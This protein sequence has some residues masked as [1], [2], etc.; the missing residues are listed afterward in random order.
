MALDLICYCTRP[1][2]EAE[3]LRSQV[4][5]KLGLRYGTGLV[6]YKV[7]DADEIDREIAGEFGLRVGSKFMISVNDKEALASELGAVAAVL[8]G[9]FGTDGILVLLNNETPMG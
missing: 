7:R 1:S 9:H 8:K 6:H 2:T 5:A 4:A 3:T